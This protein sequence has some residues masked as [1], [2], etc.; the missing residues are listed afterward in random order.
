MSRSLG[1]RDF[2]KIGIAQ[3]RRRCQDLLGDDDVVVPGE[4][5]HDVDGRIVDWPK[6]PTEFGQRFT[7]DSLDQMSQDV[8]ENVDLLITEPISIRDKQVGNASQ[9]FDTL[10][11][12]AALDCVF[13]LGNK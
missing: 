4:P 9:R 3:P 6:A 5:S 11:L 8:V 1:A 12:R 7:F 13:Q 10:I 2:D